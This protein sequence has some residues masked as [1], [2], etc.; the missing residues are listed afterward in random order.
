MR[1][2]MGPGGPAAEPIPGRSFNER[3][4]PVPIPRVKDDSSLDEAPQE[5]R[6]R[7]LCVVNPVAGPRGSERTARAL[8]EKAERLG[9]DLDMVRTRPGLNGTAAATTRSG[10]Y[11]AYIAVGGDGT[12]ME[13]ARAAMRDGVPMAIVPRG[14]ANAV[15]WH[16]GLPFDVSQALKVAMYGQPVR[17]DIARTEGREFLIMAGLGFDAAVIRDA[18][19]SMK[20]RLGFL[21]Y[22]YAALKNL[23]RRPNR[24]RVTLDDHEPFRAWGASAVI[25]NIGTLAGNIR[26]VKQV[27]PRDGL[28]DLVIVSPQ[29]VSDFF[30]L[31]YL[32]IRGR[33]EDDPRVR[34]YRAANIRV[35]CQPP[36]PLEIDGDDIEGKHSVLEAGVE[37]EALTLLVPPEGTMRFRWIPD[38]PWANGSRR[39]KDVTPRKRGS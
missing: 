14:T 2:D 19:R 6:R 11:E 35:E 39:R 13:V 29:R 31:I 18:T 32:G 23:G 15:A 17:I 9:V 10:D 24:Y 5:A 4:E 3:R 34:Y 26:L 12:V 16:F 22:L 7:M 36:S 38:V 21:A 33:L 20:R 25:A 37:A 28:L 30:R 1:Q 27:N 8:K